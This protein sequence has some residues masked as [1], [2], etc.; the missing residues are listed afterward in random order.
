[1]GEAGARVKRAIVDRIGS[2]GV[3]APRLGVLRG[4]E[5]RERRT[6]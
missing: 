6:G 4:G 3:S 5:T 2:I 1:M